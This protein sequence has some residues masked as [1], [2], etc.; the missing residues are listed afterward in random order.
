MGLLRRCHL[1]LSARKHRAKVKRAVRFLKSRSSLQQSCFS[2]RAFSKFCCS[3]LS[4]VATRGRLPVARQLLPGQ[5]SMEG[6][7]QLVRV[8]QGSNALHEGECHTRY[9]L[10]QSR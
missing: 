1:S 10:C 8:R 2:Q 4:S 7:V 3:F 5:D 9:V 6:R